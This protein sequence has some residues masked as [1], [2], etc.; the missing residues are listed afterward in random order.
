[1]DIKGEVT[2]DNGLDGRRQESRQPLKRIP[3]RIIL[4]MDR[5]EKREFHLPL[6]VQIYP[7]AKALSTQSHQE[8]V[9][10]T[11]DKT[12][13]LNNLIFISYRLHS[14]RGLDH[15]EQRERCQQS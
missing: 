14:L 1:M 13:I 3:V 12:Y 6:I 15:C 4:R 7:K 5:T 9:L 11:G 8:L 10:E 2:F